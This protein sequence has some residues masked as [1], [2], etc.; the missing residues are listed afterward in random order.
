MRALAVELNCTDDL[1]ASRTYCDFVLVCFR[2]QGA[3]IFLLTCFMARLLFAP[4]CS[5]FQNFRVSQ[6]A[7]TAISRKRQETS[8]ALE[9]SFVYNTDIPESSTATAYIS[10]GV[11]LTPVFTARNWK[12]EELSKSLVSN[13]FNF[14]PKT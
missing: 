10:C 8:S 5:D 2:L 9:N 14:S 1:S 12:K 13:F 6:I 3:L 4:L 7:A 11:D